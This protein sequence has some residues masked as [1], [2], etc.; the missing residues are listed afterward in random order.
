[1]ADYP[2]FALA[3]QRRRSEQAPLRRPPRDEPFVTR[4]DAADDEVPRLRSVI[5]DL[6]AQVSSLTAENARL[7][8]PEPNPEDAAAQQRCRRLAEQVAQ[9]EAALET[10]RRVIETKDQMLA[11]VQAEYDQVVADYQRVLDLNAS[12]L[13]ELRQAKAEI[14][15][16]EDRIRGTR[17]APPPP[18][19]APEMSVQPPVMPPGEEWAD[20]VE[21]MSVAE[22]REVLASLRAQK[23]DI[24][25]RLN[26]APPKG[27]SLATVRREQAEAEGELDALNRRIARIRIQLRKLREE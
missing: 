22:M 8:A 2:P 10:R 18:R 26:R 5:A 7:R 24:E 12:Q 27:R 25:R 21:S 15:E 14:W 23:D 3:L 13:S 20:G 4:R 19:P 9:L 11:R 16:L 6:E 1:M 17:P